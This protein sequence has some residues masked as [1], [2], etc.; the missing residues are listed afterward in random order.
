MVPSLE[1]GVMVGVVRA[2]SVVAEV[3][4]TRWALG[5]FSRVW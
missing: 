1:A 3:C 5:G 2:G 4:R